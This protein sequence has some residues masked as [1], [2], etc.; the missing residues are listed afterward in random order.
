MLSVTESSSVASLPSF[1]SLGP[2]LPSFV[3]VPCPWPSYLCLPLRDSS[4]SLAVTLSLHRI[5]RV[6]YLQALIGALMGSGRIARRD[7]TPHPRWVSDK[8]ENPRREAGVSSRLLLKPV[9]YF[10]N[11]IVRVNTRSPNESRQK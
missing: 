10:K 4:L 8:S 1:L 3:S 7:A 9:A 2:A 5:T 11:I 6:Y